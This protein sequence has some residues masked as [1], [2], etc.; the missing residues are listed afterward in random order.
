M[1][2]FDGVTFTSPI[3]N[4]FKEISSEV[5][6]AHYDADAVCRIGGQLI[7][8]NPK[9]LEEISKEI[10]EATGS[11][12]EEVY[13]D[14]KHYVSKFPD[15]A[16]QFQLIRNLDIFSYGLFSHNIVMHHSI[17]DGLLSDLLSLIADEQPAL[18]ADEIK[19]KTL[20]ISDLQTSNPDQI[21]KLVIDRYVADLCRESIFKKMD[22]ICRII[23]G[24]LPTMKPRVIEGYTRDDVKL[25]NIDDRRHEIIHNPL[26]RVNITDWQEIADYMRNSSIAFVIYVFTKFDESD[27]AK[28]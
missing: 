15:S 16:V 27:P 19:K 14:G 28:P 26:K 3:A 9:A 12:Y 21:M 4:K 13:G 22:A 5:I 1:T 6:Q 10:I 8:K 23:K 20:K 2:P 18:F 25:K 7:T 11:A 24:P 17:F